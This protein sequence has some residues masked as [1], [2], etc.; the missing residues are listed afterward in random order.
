MKCTLHNFAPEKIALILD[1]IHQSM[2]KNCHFFLAERI[3]PEDKTT[4]HFN[5][6]SHLLMRMLFGCETYAEA[7]YKQSFN[8][9]GFSS[10]IAASQQWLA[11]AYTIFRRQPNPNKSNIL[12]ASDSPL[13]TST[14]PRKHTKITQA[15]TTPKNHQSL[16]KA[17]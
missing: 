10:E 2:G 6:I 1:H 3:V 14:S 5:Q 16:N 12:I 13:A 11:G 15:V 8:Q 4:L 17:H 9:A 7:F